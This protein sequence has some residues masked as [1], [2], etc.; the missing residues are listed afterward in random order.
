M[1]RDE[2]LA[3]LRAHE[4]N[5]SYEETV[6]HSCDAYIGQKHYGDC[7]FANAITWLEDDGNADNQHILDTEDKSEPPRR[8][9]AWVLR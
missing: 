3:L 6:C 5:Q 7:A 4:W 2:L 8:L 1:T 9:K